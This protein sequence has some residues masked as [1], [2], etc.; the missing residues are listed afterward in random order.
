M[1]EVDVLRGRMD[2]LVALDA[3]LETS[4]V[5]HAAERASL[6]QPAMSR[7]LARLRHAFGDPLLVRS[8][9]R[10]LLTPR[11]DALRQPVHDLLQR[12]GEL[13]APQHFNPAAAERVFRA[14]I[15]DVLAA[16]LLPPLLERLRTEAPGCR[17]EL[18]PW[19]GSRHQT[20]DL[21]VTSEATAF[22][23]L[24]MTPLYRDRDVLA[25]RPGI[26]VASPLALPHVAVVAAGMA[27]DPVDRWLSASGQTRHIALVVPHYLLA[28][29][30]IASSDYVAVL[31]SWLVAGPGAAL[32]VAASELPLQ[33]EPDQVW[34]L[35][36]P[37][38]DADLASR[39]L[40][41][42]VTQVARPAD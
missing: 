30:L 12:M 35:Y 39:W 42:L 29:Q 19:P 13:L 21:V 2:L 11:A 32:G 40:R 23:T 37:H 1:R 16:V 20:P 15:P 27:E 22:P 9:G 36:P 25:H 10:T 18:V 3:L 7:A 14:V 28:L 31:P 4:N 38:H 17:L 6:S 33:Q 5:T 34:L 8:G 41:D 24:R 26:S